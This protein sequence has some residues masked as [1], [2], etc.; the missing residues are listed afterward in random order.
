ML[1]D[2]TY[3][4]SPYRP[5]STTALYLVCRAIFCR[6]RCSAID[7]FS[8]LFFSYPTMALFFLYCSSSSISSAQWT[9]SSM[10]SAQWTSQWTS[11]W[12]V[13]SLNFAVNV[14]QHSHSSTQLTYHRLGFPLN[15]SGNVAG[16]CSTWDFIC[17]DCL[18]AGSRSLGRSFNPN[19][20]H[21]LCKLRTLPS[22]VRFLQCLLLIQWT[23]SRVFSLNLS[24][25]DASPFY[26]Y[27]QTLLLMLCQ[28]MQWMP[29]PS[30]NV[31]GSCSTWAFPM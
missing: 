20:E 12:L 14:S 22:S 30:W 15:V 28:L 29:H 21:W 9:S 10:S 25:I 2:V 26:I 7:E 23:S 6:G 27:M 1:I 5:I 19:R 3:Q 31:A 24:S 11:S 18:H 4:R 13:F 16:S 17:S 8:I